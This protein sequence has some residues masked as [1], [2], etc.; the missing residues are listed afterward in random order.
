MSFFLWGPWLLAPV[1]LAVLLDQLGLEPSNRWHPVAWMGHGIAWLTRW[2]PEKGNGRLVVWGGLITVT[3]I[4]VCGLSGGLVHL[5]LW[6]LPPWL[7]WTGEALV[8]KTAFSWH[9]LER[10]AGIVAD[11]LDK[12]DLAGARQAVGRHLVSRSTDDLHESEISA[13]TIE[14]LSENAGDS[15]VAP[16]FFYLIGGLPGAL[17]YRFVNTADA[18]LGYR[19]ARLEWVGKIPA[20]LDDVL[21]W[22][23]A[24]LTALFVVSAGGVWLRSFRQ[25]WR[26]WRRDAGLTLSPNAGHPMSAAA[27]V[28]GVRL[29]KP[30]TYTLGDELCPPQ[31]NDIGRT[32]TLLQVSLTAMLA[33]LAMA[34]VLG[35]WVPA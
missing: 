11:H 27:G 5:A 2:A 24:R 34:L 29:S 14:S 19:Q 7:A 32:L 15:V 4:A 8:L 25:G 12:G 1:L 20:R 13:A 28:L 30:E 3:G 18:M 31:A 22:L 10:A 33:G 21:N 9:G 23:P 6:R 26:I 35:S 17:V 16:M